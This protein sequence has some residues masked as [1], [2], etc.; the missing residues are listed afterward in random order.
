ML[1]LP[2]EPP[3]NRKRF[4]AAKPT[5]SSSDSQQNSDCMIDVSSFASQFFHRRD[6]RGE[7]SPKALS[8]PSSAYAPCWNR[9]EAV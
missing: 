1:P 4:V 5:L 3:P 7:I 6:S 8:E 9:Q 2:D